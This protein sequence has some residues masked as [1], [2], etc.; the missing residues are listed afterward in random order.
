V[1][2]GTFYG[3]NA[4]FDREMA[5]YSPGAVHLL[6]ECEHCIACDIKRYDFLRGSEEY[7]LRWPVKASPL[8]RL[9]VAT[10]ASFSC[11]RRE[12]RHVLDRLRPY[13]RRIRSGEKRGRRAVVA[14]QA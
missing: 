13:V 6:R 11:V 12:C 1:D 7:K 3:W 14:G 2:K 10:P 4:A 8:Y 9:C 5:R